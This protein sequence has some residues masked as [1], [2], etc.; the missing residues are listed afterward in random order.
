M[1]HR[2]EGPLFIT[3]KSRM[4]RCQEELNP[5]AIRLRTFPSPSL[6]QTVLT[7]PLPPPLSLGTE[8]A[9]QCRNRDFTESEVKQY[10]PC[11]PLG[12]KVFY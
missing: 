10:P 3:P 6:N 8:E 11:F 1:T 4:I 9:H 7:S 12:E 5:R 2:T